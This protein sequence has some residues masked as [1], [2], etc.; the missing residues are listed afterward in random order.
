[1]ST[2]NPLLVVLKTLLLVG[3]SIRLTKL[4]LDS[5]PPPDLALELRD[6]SSDLEMLKDELIAL[7]DALESA[8]IETPPPP[9]ELF[10]AV[11]AL[12]KRVEE[13][14]LAGAAAVQTLAL[15][16]QAIDVAVQVMSAAVQ[17]KA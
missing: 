3:E 4:A 16:A 14:R 9:A 8:Q 7:A 2:T 11:S 10:D 1:M 12:A 6:R 5:N 13:E 17:V 15:A